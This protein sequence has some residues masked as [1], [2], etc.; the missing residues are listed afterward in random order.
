MLKKSLKVAIIIFILV[1]TFVGV[2]FYQKYFIKNET[3]F[4]KKSTTNQLKETKTETKDQSQTESKVSLSNISD[5]IQKIQV[6][7]KEIK[8]KEGKKEINF[9]WNYKD[10]NYNFS[11][12]FYQSVFDFYQSQPKVYKYYG[13]IPKGWENDYYGIFLQV[14]RDDTS[15]PEI[16][17]RFRNLQIENSLSDDELVEL[18]TAFVQAI[19]YDDSKA[20]NILQNLGSEKPRYPYEVLYENEAV[21]SGKSFLLVQLL[22]ELDFGAALFEYEDQNHMAVGIECPQENSTYNSG[23]CYTET[24][25]KGHKIGIVPFLD[26][27]S[28]GA[29]ERREFGYFEE[30][31][32]PKDKDNGLFKPE[33]VKIYQQ[34]DGKAYRGVERTLAI[35][36]EIEALEEELKGLKEKLNQS[37]QEVKNLEEKIASMETQLETYKENR[38]YSNYNELVQ[39]YNDLVIEV[40]EKVNAHNELVAE[41]NAKIDRYNGLIKSY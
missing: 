36:S 24:T 29:V 40:K 11:E 14:A 17:Q 13:D 18:I 39:E 4:W 19:P 26:S 33:N 37:K 27:Q 9:S 15:I 12:V 34:T 35:I 21:C 31:G 22:R 10:V 6:K 8:V 38:E 28:R 41:F 2:D 25:T 32:E 30:K 3:P 20:E 23:Y 7:E 5:E 1:F 16:A